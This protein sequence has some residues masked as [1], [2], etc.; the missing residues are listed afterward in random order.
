MMRAALAHGLQTPM[1]LLFGARHETDILYD[2]EMREAVRAHPFVRFEPSLS[3]PLESWTGRRGY[4]QTHVRALWEELGAV[5]GETPHA[6]VCGLTRMVGSVRD[7]LRKEM[8]LGRELV[9]TER[10][11]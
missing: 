11:D 3:Q 2:A 5:A 6:Y 1:W 10:Y 8:G 4:V 7:L 9:H